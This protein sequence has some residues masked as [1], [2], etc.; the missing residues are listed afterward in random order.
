MHGQLGGTPGRTGT[1][2]CNGDE[3]CR[4]YAAASIRVGREARPGLH[5]VV[6]QM[7]Q[8]VSPVPVQIWQR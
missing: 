8:G 4:R 7:W 3:P 5:K 2:C 6:V 1:H